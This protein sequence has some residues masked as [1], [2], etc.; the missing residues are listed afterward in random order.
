M[1]PEA[2]GAMLSMAREGDYTSFT[3]DELIGELKFGTDIKAS[4]VYEDGKM[5]F[6]DITWPNDAQ[7]WVSNVYYPREVAI[8]PGAAFVADGEG[9]LAIKSKV[10]TETE[11]SGY[12][13]FTYEETT[14]FEM[15]VANA[16][17]SVEVTFVNP[18]DAEYTAYLEAEDVTLKQWA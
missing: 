16:D 10:W 6:Q 2:I 15:A 3:T 11:S 13:V 1:T 12:G 7:G 5:G 17:Y 14:G 8:A 4:N 9:Y 18:G